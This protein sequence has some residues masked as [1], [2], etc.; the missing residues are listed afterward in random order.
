MDD[1]E[2]RLHRLEDLIV[3][4]GLAGERERQCLRVFAHVTFGKGWA[5]RPA[6]VEQL[7]AE[8]SHALANPAAFIEQVR[9]V[10]ADAGV[11]A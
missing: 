1:P 6:D 11:P 3:R 7:I 5:K 4:L 9:A 2:D 8:M 10:A